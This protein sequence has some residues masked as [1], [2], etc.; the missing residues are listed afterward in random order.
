MGLKFG[1]LDPTGAGPAEAYARTKAIVDKFQQRYG[2]LQCRDLTARFEDFASPERAHS[3]GEIV[4]FVFNE[5]T[6]VLNAPDEKP[7]WR[8]SWWKDYFA[9]RDKIT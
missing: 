4:G 1:K 7:E 2:T 9:R 8:E 3:C 5:L 6:D